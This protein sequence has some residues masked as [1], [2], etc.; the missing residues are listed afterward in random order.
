M[1]VD[2]SWLA[3]IQSGLQLHR[4]K[5]RMREGSCGWGQHLLSP[6]TRMENDIM[7]RGWAVTDLVFCTSITSAH[8][9]NM[10]QSCCSMMERALTL[11]GCARVGLR[12]LHPRSHE[13]TVIFV[14]V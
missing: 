8:V 11:L 6:P 12:H 13:C 2:D 9:E 7:S 3:V 10:Q 5:A 4:L 1:R 14:K